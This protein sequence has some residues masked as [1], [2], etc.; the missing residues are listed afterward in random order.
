MGRRR[1][2]GRRAKSRVMHDT[3]SVQEWYKINR[4]TLQLKDSEP[5]VL[6]LY[7]PLFDVDEGAKILDEKNSFKSLNGVRNDISHKL[8][9]MR[10]H[11]GSICFFG[12][13]KGEKNI[14]KQVTISKDVPFLHVIYRKPYLKPLKNILEIG[15]Q[16]V[17]ITMDHKR[18]KI[19]VYSGNELVEEINIRTYL[20]GR[21]SKGGW[22]QKRFQQNRDIQIRHFFNKVKRNLKELVDDNIELILLGG[23]GL[24]RKEFQ[25]VLGSKLVKRIQIVDG[26]FFGSTRNEITQLIITN[27]DKVRK[28]TELKLLA[29]LA[30]PAKHGRVI[31]RNEEIEKKLKDGAVKTLFLAA[32]YYATSPKENTLI[33]RMIGLAKRKDATVEFI[34]D[35]TAR[36]RLHKFGNLVAL[37]RYKSS[38]R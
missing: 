34:T 31:T 11:S 8:N 9:K 36:R 37:L 26:I 30:A 35:A 17:V 19:D 33:R 13:S 7:M 15:Y 25:R 22:S 20:R 24:A 29:G 2:K 1:L 10:Y 4:F 18:A 5:P 38:H 3:L 28:T 14:V 23:R 12:W 27:L 32:D 6:S 21:H 16:V